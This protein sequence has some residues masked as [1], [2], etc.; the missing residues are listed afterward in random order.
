[1]GAHARACVAAE[2]RRKRGAKATT[3]RRQ[4]GAKASQ[5]GW[6]NFI[7]EK[8]AKKALPKLRHILATAQT[9]YPPS[10]TGPW[11]A[12]SRKELL[13]KGGGHSE[14]SKVARLSR[15]FPLWNTKLPKHKW[16]PATTAH[17]MLDVWLSSDAVL[18]GAPIS[19]QWWACSMH[20]EMKSL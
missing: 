9:T 4:S 15:C 7:K 12:R 11:R 18:S 5:K 8:A 1:M 19:H 17:W 2:K 14:L 6:T 16:L 20:R 13:P 3:T 10:V